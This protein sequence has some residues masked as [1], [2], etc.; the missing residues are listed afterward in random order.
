MT[1]SERAFEDRLRAALAEPMTAQQIAALDARRPTAERAPVV[2]LLRGRTVRRSLL[3]V[4]AIAIVLVAWQHEKIPTIAHHIVGAN[5]PVP[6][7]PKK[8]PGNRFDVV[9]VFTPPVPPATPWGF[10][11]VPQQLLVGDTDTVIPPII[12][13]AAA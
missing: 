11:Q 4:A 2:L 13:S 1:G 7:F 5:P 8:W 12:P 9:W 6:P 3:L 10:A